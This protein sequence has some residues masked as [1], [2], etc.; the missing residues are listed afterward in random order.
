MIRLL[1]NEQMRA[2]DAHTINDLGIPSEELM[3][4]AGVCIAD[5]VEKAVFET[6]AKSVLVVCGCG[7]NGGDGYVCASELI[8]RGHPVQLYQIEG[9]FSQDLQRERARYTGPYADSLSCGKG[10][11]IVDCIFGT[12]LGRPVEGRF[13]DVIESI[14]ASHEEGAYVIAA[15]IPS[16]LSGDSGQVLGHA[17]HA[18]RT[19]AVAEFK[20]GHFLADGPDYTGK[21]VKKDIGIVLCD[22]ETAQIY[23]NEDIKS[24]FPPRKRNTHKGSYGTAQLVCGTDTYMG[25]AALSS[26]GALRSGCG[27]VKLKT[28]QKVKESLVR[29]YPQVIFS[30]ATDMNAGCILIG[31]GS[32][33]SKELYGTISELLRDYSGTLVLDAD[34]LNTISKYGVDVLKRHSCS[35][36]MTPHMKE[37]SRLTGLS[38][39]EISRDPVQAAK[40]FAEK[41]KVTLLL[42][43]ATSIICEASDAVV[44]SSSD[45]V[46]DS[47]CDTAAGTSKSA[48]T[49]FRVAV[50]IRGNSALAKGGSGDMLAGFTAGSIARGLEPFDACAASSY[51]LGTAAELA[52]ADLTEY[53]VTARDVEKKIP[54]AIKRLWL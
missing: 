17:V 26:C 32:G 13:A 27:Y 25:A 30:D 53:C 35:V 44:D 2:A 36:V 37:F 6:G 43:S 7:N 21:A 47:S 20:Y 52:S 16:G 5:E 9:R 18:D 33:V 34:A 23:E 39:A 8:R 15:D 51:I 31:C 10:D 4:R 19:V 54:D 38:V 22:A 12:G 14:N 24:F 3:H 42:K 11:I 28:T 41:Y 50:N 49:A 46:V 29:R 40:D 45:T 48:G 1:T